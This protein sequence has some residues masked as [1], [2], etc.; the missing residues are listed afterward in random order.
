MVRA[1]SVTRLTVRVWVKAMLLFAC[2]MHAFGDDRNPPNVV[3]IFVDDLGY[4]ASGLYGCE[5]PTPNIQRLADEGARFT[6]GYVTSPV[7]SP[8]R[9][10]L[11]TGRSQQRFGHD[12]LPEGAANGNG[13]LP[14]GE[15]TLADAMKQ[16]GYVTG[17][18]GKWHLGHSEEFHPINRG[19]DEFFG[20]LGASTNYADHA[21]E[22]VVVRTRWGMEL[23]LL[24]YSPD[25]LTLSL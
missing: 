5:A 12:Y 9:A 24:S 17:M 16:A 14:V 15:I 20:L 1:S 23:P 19:F 7:C 25:D 6:D 4:C 13:G 18:V 11:L 10:G 21:R 22:D 2:A 3:L 8:S